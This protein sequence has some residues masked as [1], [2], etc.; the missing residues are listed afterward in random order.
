[1]KKG[2][3]YKTSG[4]EEDSFEPGLPG[5]SAAKQV[6]HHRQESHG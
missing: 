6:G 2:G 1:M 3:R 5:T 4:L